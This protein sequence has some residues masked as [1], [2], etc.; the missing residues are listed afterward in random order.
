MTDV[1]ATFDSTG[2][3]NKVTEYLDKTHKLNDYNEILNLN[4]HLFD[5]NTAE[6]TKL[7]EFN[8]M[9]VTKLMK[10]K[11]QYMLTDYAINEMAMYT[12][13]LMF[14]II[15]VAFLLV[16]VSKATP[17]TKKQLIVISGGTAIFYLVVIMFMLKSSANRRKYSWSQW[18]WDPVKQGARF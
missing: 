16:F 4:N 9:I 11:Q 13:A 5:V 1:A 12:R 18:Y 10:M 15:V 17:E 7:A 8:S 14:T 6:E 2:F 3:I